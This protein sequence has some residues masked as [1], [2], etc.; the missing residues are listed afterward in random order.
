MQNP[1]LQTSDRM[2]HY[3]LPRRLEV[4]WCEL[5]AK[6]V[7]AVNCKVYLLLSPQPTEMLIRRRS[8]CL[9][10]VS[11]H[12]CTHARMRVE[13]E[14]QGHE[15]EASEISDNTRLTRDS[16]AFFRLRFRS[17]WVVPL[18]DEFLRTVSRML[19]GRRRIYNT[20]AAPPALKCDLKDTSLRDGP[21]F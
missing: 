10:P 14:V 18:F 15:F 12:A 1:N 11:V 7:S 21:L 17:L 16:L 5:L 6:T 2:R 8:S 20:T 13:A 3:P 4:L 9:R 19:L